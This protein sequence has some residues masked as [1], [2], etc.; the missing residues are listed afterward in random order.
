MKLTWPTTSVI[1]EG[2]TLMERLGKLHRGL[3]VLLICFALEGFEE[4]A[5]RPT[6]KRVRCLW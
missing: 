4:T 6:F 3:G 1:R 2:Q 5:S